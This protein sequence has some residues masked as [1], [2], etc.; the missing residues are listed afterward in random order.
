[1]CIGAHICILKPEED[2]MCPALYVQPCPRQDLSL[3]LGPS[4]RPARPRATHILGDCG[5]QKRVLDP[6]DLVS[7]DG[8]RCRV[9]A[10]NQNPVFMQ[11]QSVLLTPETPLQSHFFL[12]LV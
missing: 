11:E 8:Y 4:R 2:A 1:M 10:G 5:G 9:G 3:N 7:I 12:F 6:M